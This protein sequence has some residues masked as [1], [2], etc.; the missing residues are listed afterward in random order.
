MAASE[1][2]MNR[3]RKFVIALGASTFAAPM[4]SFAQQQAKVWRIGYAPFGSPIQL[5]PGATPENY[6]TMD[7][8]TAQGA[9][10]DLLKAIAKDAGVQVQFLAFLA[11]E[12]SE[13]IDSGKIDIRAVAFTNMDQKSMEISESILNDSEVLIANK[14]DNTSYASYIDLKGL[15]VGSRTGTVSENDLK[16][17]GFDVKSYAS[18][19]ELFKA[20]DTGEVKVAINTSYIPTAYTLSRGQFPNVRIVKSYRPK[21]P[22][23]AG[24]GVRKNGSASLETVNISLKKLKSDG[25]VRAIFDQ[26]G[27]A[28]AL[29]K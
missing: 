5:L 6:R 17:N 10:I 4:F 13:A 1:E 28:D 12:L 9:M 2:V 26:Y 7:A 3:R 14:A 22:S 29:V 21:L 24:I 16:A 11:G 20:V 8:N 27:I 19:P 23:V 25:T 18:A 15:V